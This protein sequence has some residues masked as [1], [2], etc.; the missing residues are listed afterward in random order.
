M[1][2]ATII[3]SQNLRTVFNKHSFNKWQQDVCEEEFRDRGRERKV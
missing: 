2:L 1:M 3:Y